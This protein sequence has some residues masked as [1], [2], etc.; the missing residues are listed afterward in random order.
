MQCLRSSMGKVPEFLTPFTLLQVL[1]TISLHGWPIIPGPENSGKSI[2][3]SYVQSTYPFVQ[4]FQYILGLAISDFNN[5]CVYP[6]LYS[7]E[8]TIVN[9]LLLALMSHSHLHACIALS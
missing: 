3:H 9:Q 7:S 1:S 4:F 8:P 2:V 6:L 5:G